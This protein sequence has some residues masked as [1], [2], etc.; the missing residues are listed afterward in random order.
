MKR[1]WEA[2]MN[3]KVED[4]TLE[5]PE[6]VFTI[7]PRPEPRRGSRAARIALEE[8]TDYTRPWRGN[9]GSD[10]PPLPLRRPPPPAAPYPVESL[11]ELLSGAVRAIEARTQAPAALAAQNVL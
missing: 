8:A 10:E 11:G 4:E 3:E 5:E 2:C 6:W 9:A 1:R 7:P